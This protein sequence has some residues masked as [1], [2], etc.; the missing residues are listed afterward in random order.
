MLGL[1]RGAGTNGAAISGGVLLYGRDDNQAGFAQG[2]AIY[3]SDTAGTLANSAGTVEVAVGYAIDADS[4][5]FNPN[6][7]KTSLTTLQKALVAGITSS[8]AEINQLD[9]ATITA[10][11]LTEAGTFFGSTDMSAAEAETLTDTSDAS[12][13]HYHDPYET[14][15]DNLSDNIRYLIGGLGDGMTEVAT[16]GTT[17]RTVMNTRLYTAGAGHDSGINR[18]L[19]NDDG[20][21]AATD[22]VQFADSPNFS[23]VIAVSLEQLTNNDVFIG[24]DTA[25]LAAAYADATTAADHVAF[26]VQ[27][28]TLYASVG[29]GATQTR[30][31][32]T[33]AYTLTDF[34]RLEIISTGGTNAV[35]KI[36]D[37]TVATLTTNL[38]NSGD[39]WFNAINTWNGAGA[40]QVTV[41]RH[42]YCIK[43][44]NL[45]V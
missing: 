32:V 4:I 25:A 17:T 16:G 11:Q 15:I 31:D 35:F 19:A 41:L 12:S 43:L 7:W 14:T 21:G 18:A 36:N 37:T 5:D 29:D 40:G 3:V 24:F 38:P 20:A 13:L 45:A 27:D 8:A 22:Y 23:M 39:V 6:R 30:S 34:N 1:A 33:G 28:G 9:G 44:T 10:A 42:P 26:M 2:D